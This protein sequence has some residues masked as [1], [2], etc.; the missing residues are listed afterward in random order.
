MSEQTPYTEPT[1]D[2]ESYDTEPGTEATEEGDTLTPPSGAPDAVANADTDRIQASE[3]ARE[4]DP[5]QLRSGIHP[6]G[7]TGDSDPASQMNF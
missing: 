7:G 1:R 5:Y 4:E 3:V 2:E 6:E